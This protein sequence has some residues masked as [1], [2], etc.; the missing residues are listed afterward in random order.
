M[1]SINVPDALKNLPAWLIWRFEENGTSKPRKVPY[2]ANNTRRHGVQGRPEDRAQLV[3]FA[4]ATRAAAK[5]NASGVGFAPHADF[6]VVALDFDNCIDSQG[7]IHSDIQSVLGASYAERS[8]SG[9]GIRAL[10]LGQLG[11]LKAHGE[12]FGFE[13][14]STKGFVTITGDVLPECELLGNENT[15]A[16]ITP[17]V[18]ALCQSRFLSLIHI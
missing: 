11:D 1:P 3:T 7:A 17:E 15:I 8:P 6:N 4:E 13:T 16:P 14:F 5:R 10:F 12:P 9:K 18:T 2:Y